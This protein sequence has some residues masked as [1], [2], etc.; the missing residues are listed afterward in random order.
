LFSRDAEHEAEQRIIKDYKGQL[1]ADV[2]KVG[3]HGSK[4]ASSLAYVQVIAPEAA[5]ISVLLV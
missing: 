2:L 4:T 5:T 1:H 3:H